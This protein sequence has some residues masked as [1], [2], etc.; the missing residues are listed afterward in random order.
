MFDTDEIA[1]TRTLSDD[2]TVTVN[3]EGINQIG[4]PYNISIELEL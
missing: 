4:S 1:L 3:A 2:E